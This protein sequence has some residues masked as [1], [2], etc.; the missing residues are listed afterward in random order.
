MRKLTVLMAVLLICGISYG[1]EVKLNIS[2]KTKPGRPAYVYKGVN[3]YKGKPFKPGDIRTI[4]LTI[5]VGKTTISNEL[6][7]K[8]IADD[9]GR[10][11]KADHTYRAYIM[12]VR[13]TG[14]DTAAIPRALTEMFRYRTIDLTEKQV[15]SKQITSTKIENFFT[16]ED[17]NI[18]G[19][20]DFA[21]T[22]DKRYHSYPVKNYVW[23]S[24]KD[25]LVYW[26][27]LSNA[28]S[29]TE[30]RRSRMLSVIVTTKTG[31]MIPKYYHVAKD[32]SL[33]PYAVR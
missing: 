12:K 5:P 27:G 26:Y 7:Y 32:T 15:L 22:G 21:F 13:P 3:P 17:F 16:V 18:D 30:D 23:V 6:T 4:Q 29:D 1:Q 25:K 10:I 8:L 20:A 11:Y 31:S 9:D 24:I 28:P 14:K 2:K 19:K 33:V